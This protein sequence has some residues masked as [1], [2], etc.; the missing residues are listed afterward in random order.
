MERRKFLKNILKVTAIASV[1]AVVIHELVKNK[2][3]GFA[4]KPLIDGHGEYMDTTTLG[5]WTCDA[6]TKTIIQNG[7]FPAEWEL[8]KS[9][10]SI[11]YIGDEDKKGASIPE[12]QRFLR[13]EWEGDDKLVPFKFQ[14]IRDFGPEYNFTTNYKI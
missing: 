5:K 6:E 11:R 9:N 13:D 3:L 4:G 1:P 12:L 8:N 14:V 10:G 7:G 2:P